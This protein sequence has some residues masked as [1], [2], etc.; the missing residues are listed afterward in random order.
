MVHSQEM[1][2]CEGAVPSPS[3]L[4]HG[5]SIGTRSQGKSESGAATGASA[6]EAKQRQRLKEIALLDDENSALKET[7]NRCQ[8]VL[9]CQQ[10]EPRKERGGKPPQMSPA[11]EQSSFPCCSKD[12]VRESSSRACWSGTVGKGRGR[13]GTR[14]QLAAKLGAYIPSS[15][16][17]ITSPSLLPLFLPWFVFFL[18]FICWGAPTSLPAE[19]LLP[20]VCSCCLHLME[21]LDQGEPGRS[22]RGWRGGLGPPAS[23]K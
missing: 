14:S 20:G 15:S 3:L 22:C 23:Q 18:L 1:F 7:L 9:V 10:P 11:L 17:V 19:Q 4:E 6:G 21:Q 13:T 12:G 5:I 16:S 8:L 2:P